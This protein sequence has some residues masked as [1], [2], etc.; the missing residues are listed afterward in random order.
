MRDA[1]GQR[2]HLTDIK[3]RI[4]E[5]SSID[6]GMSEVQQAVTQLADERAIT[7]IERS[8]MVLVKG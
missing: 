1:K 5:Q 7:Y 8:N 6:V 4:E 3:R 2:L